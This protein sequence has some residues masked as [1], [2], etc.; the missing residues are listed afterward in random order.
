M[1][2]QDKFMKELIKFLDE[3]HSGWKK[4]PKKKEEKDKYD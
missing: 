2:E 1:R 4:N 3:G